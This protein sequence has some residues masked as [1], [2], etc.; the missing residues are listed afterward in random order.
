MTNS[1]TFKTLGTY[2]EIIYFSDLTEEE[3]KE[4]DYCE[5]GDQFF[6]CNNE[7]YFLG[8]FMRFNSENR[9]QDFDGYY[10]TSYFSAYL[11]KL[12][13]CGDCIET[14]AKMLT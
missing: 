4:Y 5:D 3:Q 6:R 13:D 10:G 11:V 14:F 2:L 12:S 1:T 7:I 9:V 8:D